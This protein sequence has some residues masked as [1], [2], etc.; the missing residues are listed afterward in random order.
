MGIGCCAV[1]R[2]EKSRKGPNIN[3]NIE[4][5]LLRNSIPTCTCNAYKIG[6]L[7]DLK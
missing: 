2:D 6:I 5:N 1:N 3:S 7:Y 4:S